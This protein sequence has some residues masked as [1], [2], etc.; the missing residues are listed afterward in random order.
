MNE[1]P[2][3]DLIRALAKADW[4]AVDALVVEIGQ[5]GLANGLRVIGAAFALAVN[6]RFGPETTP[7]DVA[8]WVAGIR[9]QYQGNDPLPTLE[10]EGL[11]RAALGEPELVDTIAPE[12]ALGAELLML[13]QIILEENLSATELDEFVAEA[14]QLAAQHQ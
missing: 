13:G 9:A 1:K 5:Q 11:I 8:Q 4:D 6:R 12:T 14:E 7:T 3:R 2:L 10:M